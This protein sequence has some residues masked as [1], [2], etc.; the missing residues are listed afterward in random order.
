MTK[1]E[2]VRKIAETIVE[3]EKESDGLQVEEIYLDRVPLKF[4]YTRLIVDI[5]LGYVVRAS[6]EW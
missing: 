5:H 3:Y 4:N 1:E 2:L 6:H